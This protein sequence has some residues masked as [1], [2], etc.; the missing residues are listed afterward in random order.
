MN[1]HDRGRDQWGTPSPFSTPESSTMLPALATEGP[2]RFLLVSGERDDATWGLVGA[3][4]LSED[5]ARG[6]FVI[7]PDSL[8]HGSEMVRSYRGALTRGWSDRRIFEYWAA[9]TGSMG[10]YM[11]DPEQRAGTLNEVAHLVDAL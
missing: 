10:T 3:F 8:W 4:W 9:Q 5:G 11:V 6:G 7:S 1:E 2:V